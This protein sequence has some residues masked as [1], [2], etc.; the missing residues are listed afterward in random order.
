MTELNVRVAKLA[1]DITWVPAIENKGDR[2]AAFF[3]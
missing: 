2:S 3:S 1:E